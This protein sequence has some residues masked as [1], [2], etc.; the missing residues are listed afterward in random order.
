MY[1]SRPLG[2]FALADSARPKRCLGCRLMPG[3]QSGNSSKSPIPRWSLC[4]GCI[5]R[6]HPASLFTAGR[7]GGHWTSRVFSDC[8]AW[9]RANKLFYSPPNSLDKNQGKQPKSCFAVQLLSST[10][11]LQ[12]GLHCGRR[13][14]EVLGCLVGRGLLPFLPLPGVNVAFAG[15]EVSLAGQCPS[16]YMCVCVCVCVCVCIS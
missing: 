4:D 7:S 14:Q 15:W 16:T 5:T 8:L 2:P 9:H 12:P 13:G 10:A 1:G 6:E 3:R 11:L